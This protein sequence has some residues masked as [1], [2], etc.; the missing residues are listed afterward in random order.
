MSTTTKKFTKSEGKRKIIKKTKV[1][2]TFVSK[3]TVKTSTHKS[4]KRN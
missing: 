4:S 1:E 3:T 2:T